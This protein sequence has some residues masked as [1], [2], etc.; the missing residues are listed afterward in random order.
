MSSSRPLR[1]HRTLATRLAVALTFAA[2]LCAGAIAA[3]S[4]GCALRIGSGPDGK[5]YELMAQDMARV[6]AAEVAVCSVQSIGGIPNL[7]M[8]SASEADVG[9]LSIRHFCSFNWH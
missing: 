4:D 5:L 8:L 6:C 1:S 7:V 2:G 3:G 9:D